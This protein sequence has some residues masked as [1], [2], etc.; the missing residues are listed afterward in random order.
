MMFF[1]FLKIIFDIST[2]TRFKTYKPYLILIKKKFKFFGNATAAAFTNVPLVSTRLAL[3]G[4]QLLSFI[5]RFLLFFL[6]PLSCVDIV[7]LLF[8]F[9]LLLLCYISF[10]Q[11]LV[12]LCSFCYFFLRFLVFLTIFTCLDYFYAELLIIL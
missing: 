1:H 11:F 2:S 9:L 4:F 7:L 5:G 8:F 6:I 12:W 3:P 10:L